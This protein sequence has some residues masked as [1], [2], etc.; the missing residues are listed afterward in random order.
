LIVLGVV[1]GLPLLGC[2][3]LIVLSLV[4]P[5]P[6]PPAFAPVPPGW[7]PVNPQPAEVPAGKLRPE[8]VVGLLAVAPEGC[9]AGLPWVAIARLNK[10]DLPRPPADAEITKALEEL[11]AR[12]PFTVR[13][14]AAKFSKMAV[15]EDRRK[16]VAE[17]LVRAAVSG[18]RLVREPACQALV[19]WGIPDNVPELLRA[20][21]VEPTPYGRAALIAVLGGIKDPR[22][23]DP[24]AKRLGDIRDR[25]PASK[26]L[27][28]I[29]PA[30]EE[31]VRPLLK[32]RDATTRVKACE[33]LGAVGTAASVEDLDAT[34]KD[35]DPAVA[36]AAMKALDTVKA[37]P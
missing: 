33:V 11:Q 10:S 36:Q 13:D 21:D 5:R 14:A 34:A 1:V 15:V 35:A 4:M 9:P 22:A 8:E 17:A 12:S 25:D 32:H 6:A 26:A 7:P 28:A 31:A 3:G 30:A 37:R 2:G 20:L 24:L 27:I 19:R 29:G 23:A 16:E 18:H